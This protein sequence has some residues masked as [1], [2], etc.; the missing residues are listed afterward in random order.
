MHFIYFVLF[1]IMLI[2][3]G[4]NMNILVINPP[5][6]P[7]TNASLL[8]EPLDVLSIATVIKQ[9][10]TMV[11]VID[12]DVLRMENNINAYLKEKNVIVFVFDYQL[13][14]H[15]TD[16]IKNIYE[17]IHNL[18][19]ESKVIMVGKTSTY[20]YKEF[21]E[22][23]VDVVIKGI[24]EELIND[25]IDNLENMDEL[26]AI[27]NLVF[28]KDEKII[29]TKQV[30]MKNNYKKLPMIERDF[31]DL[32]KYMET[33]TIL[34]SRGCVGGCKFCTTP[35]FFRKW[36]GRS[37][38][39]VV[40][41]IEMLIKK[42]KA[43]Q[44]MFLDDNAT[45]DKKRMMRI[46]A[47][48]KKRKLNCL[49]GAL[50]SIQVYDK[51][52]LMEMYS[53]GFRW[54]HFGL[55]SG[56]PRVLK[57]MNKEMDINRVKEI[58]HEVKEMGY[59]VRTSFILDYPGTTPEDIDM[60]RELL[61]DI[62]PH[63]LRLHYLAY[64][65]GTPIY[66]TTNNISN[67]TQYIHGSVPNIK[68]KKLEESIRNLVEDLKSDDYAFITDN[69]DWTKFNKQDKDTKIAAF[70]PIKYGMCWYE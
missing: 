66:E 30:F 15:T 22:N 55:E 45:V 48:I 7:F 50:C 8:A 29:I 59:R 18:N 35:Y 52:L 39:D 62:K 17:I 37:V 47:N 42:Y 41:E 21:L 3:G 46:C 38:S 44:I 63:E 23:G 51:E 2:R 58:I 1:I 6:K 32:S 56:S 25:V 64:R 61:K 24:V 26:K 28:K 49:F 27:P 43:K 69:I 34:T 19:R 5:N 36:D 60:T 4:K 31:V 53:V 14:L 67:K 68:N 16:T 12:M 13:P 40:D 57:S 11:Q 20:L 9:R 10:H 65:Y 70:V 33:R 54:V